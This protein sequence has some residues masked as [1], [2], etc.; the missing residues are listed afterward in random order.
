M[1]RDEKRRQECL[2]E[3]KDMQKVHQDP[4]QLLSIA[5]I[6]HLHHLKGKMNTDT[7]SLIQINIT[8][9]MVKQ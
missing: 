3:I 9:S 5:V 6:V 2:L 1:I 8:I 7:L 4:I